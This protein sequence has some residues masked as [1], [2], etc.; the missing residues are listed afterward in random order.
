MGF[1]LLGGPGTAVQAWGGC[2]GWPEDSRIRPFFFS[3]RHDGAGL[4]H[5]EF[6]I[7]E[8]VRAPL[9]AC[10]SERSGGVHCGGASGGLVTQP[11]E[12][13]ACTSD[14]MEVYRQC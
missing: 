2:Q 5:W 13:S 4:M 12:G 11:Q 8:A 1:D 9:R 10:P 3:T 7:R 14:T 6:W